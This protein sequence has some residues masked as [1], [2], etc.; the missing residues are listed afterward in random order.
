MVQ[1]LDQEITDAASEAAAGAKIVEKYFT[2][3]LVQLKAP[4]EE[5]SAP[6]LVTPKGLRVESVKSLLDEYRTAPAR[7][8]GT[9]NLADLAS[10][11][12]H[13]NRFKDPDSA[14][15]AEPDRAKP[16]LQCVFDYHGAG[17]KGA[18]RFGGHRARYAF[19]LSKEWQA[20][21]RGSGQ[22]M[23]QVAFAE[24]IEN[25]IVDIADPAL[26]GDQAKSLQAKAELQFCSPSRLL[27]LSRGLSIRQGVRAKSFTSL[28]SGEMALHFDVENTDEAG[29]P[30]KIP[31]A[32]LVTLPVFDRG[33]PYLLAARLRYRLANGAVTWWYDLYQQDIVFDD[34]FEE[35]CD[36]A[37]ASTEL[38]LFY[39]SPEA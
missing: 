11:V 14:L 31:N 5:L 10:F 36:R 25:R 19:P 13:V 37:E 27:E 33:V 38:P 16:S 21:T 6:V 28:Q 15:F 34:A 24:F 26:A 9:A 32:F 20:W 18:P 23:P 4:A 2:P 1:P 3:Q 35:A 12:A 29:A 30:L 22:Q 39:G 7:R 8:S 17:A